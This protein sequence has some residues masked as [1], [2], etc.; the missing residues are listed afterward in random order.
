MPRHIVVCQGINCRRNGSPELIEQLQQT[1]P[2][3][4]TWPITRYNCFGA[5]AAAP[6]IVVLPDRL[7]YSFVMPEYVDD[8]AAAIRRGEE[9]SGL[10]KHVRPDVMEA[11]FGV[12]EAGCS[13]P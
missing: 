8:V 4:E 12:L 13:E 3:D 5:C 2:Q 10:A 6:N 7:W 9:L 1:L 11:V